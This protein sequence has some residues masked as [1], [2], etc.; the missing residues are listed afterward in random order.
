[1]SFWSGKHVLVTGATGL[2]GGWLVE[3]LA[4]AGADVVALMRGSDRQSR[5]WASG[6]IKHISVVTGRLEDYAAVERAVV[7][8]D[9]DTIF[10]LAAQTLVGVAERSPV[11]TLETNVRGTWHVLEAARVHSQLVRRVVV[12]SSDKAYGDA[13]ELPYTEDMCL[14]GRGPYD[15]SKSCADLIATSYSSTYGVPVAIVRCAN[16]Y[17]GGDL[18]WSR[19]V[20]GTLRSLIRGEQPVLR[21]DGSFRRDYLYVEDAVDAYLCVGELMETLT[22]G[23]AFNF[24]SESPLTVMELYREICAAF[25]RPD[26]PPCILGGAQREIKSQYLRAEKARRRL[27]WSAKHDLRQGL[28]K[29]V[30]WYRAH[31]A[32]VAS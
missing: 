4:A 1:M 24:S 7:Q 28:G 6:V 16:I 14:V 13:D 12:A 8:H 25:G 22:P 27:G 17:G 29:T 5:L 11:Q 30:D 23:D 3:Q 26:T 32:A 15:V 2:V 21:S 9:V 18:N 10:H 31:L 19:L 20:P